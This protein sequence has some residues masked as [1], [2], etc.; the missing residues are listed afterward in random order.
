MDKKNQNII[1]SSGIQEESVEGANS[2]KMRRDDKR[3]CRKCPMHS[4]C[5]I[6]RLYGIGDRQLSV[7]Y[8]KRAE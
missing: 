4:K 7:K 3:C 2:W 1:P 5:T 8:L 6:N